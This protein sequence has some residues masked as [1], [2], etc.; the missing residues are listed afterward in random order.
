MAICWF[1]ILVRRER[2]VVDFAKRS[3]LALYFRI[4]QRMQVILKNPPARRGL[5]FCLPDA[6]LFQNCSLIPG[7]ITGYGGIGQGTSY[8]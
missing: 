2:R 5:V 3:G 1:A 6:A 4:I 8:G 7:G